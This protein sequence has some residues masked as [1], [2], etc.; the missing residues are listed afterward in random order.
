MSVRLAEADV[1]SK[2][3]SVRLKEGA[4]LYVGSVGRAEVGAVDSL[5]AELARFFLQM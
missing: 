1:I 5:A 2:D 3:E 4:S